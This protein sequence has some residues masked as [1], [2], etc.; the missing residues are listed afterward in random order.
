MIINVLV[1]NETVSS[2][3]KAVHG[4]SLLVR[5]DD[6]VILFDMGPDDT[7]LENAHR[8]G[9]NLDDVTL[10]VISHGHDDHGGGLRTFLD[11]ERH[12]PVYCSNHAFEPHYSVR[13]G[14]MKPIGLDITL[15]G[16]QDMRPFDGVI[17]PVPGFTLFHVTRSGGHWPASNKNLRKDSPS[18]PVQETFDHEINL[19]VKEGDN[20]ILIAG[21][22][23][24]GITN[25][26]DE[27]NRISE[28]PV[29]HVISGFHMF[30]RSSGTTETDDVIQDIARTLLE[31][32]ASFHTLH[33]TGLRAYGMMK[34]VMGDRLSYVAAGTTFTIS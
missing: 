24:H 14:V 27:A 34:T 26:L 13:N 32:D 19:L 23:H 12:V 18:G 8:M 22:A 21:C 20:R 7:F 9:E 6:Q 16:H 4:L 5:T 11:L 15:A 33:C 3:F 17:E 10:A 1:D 30:S 31:K 29:T 2:G 25:I 28:R